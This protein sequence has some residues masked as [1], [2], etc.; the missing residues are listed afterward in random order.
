M[1]WAAPTRA[2]CPDSHCV[3]GSRSARV[4]AR[5]KTLPTSRRLSGAAERRCARVRRAAQRATSAAS[6]TAEDPGTYRSRPRGRRRRPPGQPR[7]T[8]PTRPCSRGAGTACGPRR[9]G[10]LSPPEPIATP[11]AERL[12]LRPRHRD[13]FGSARQQVVRNLEQGGTGDQPVLSGG[14]ARRLIVNE[15]AN[16]CDGEPA[17]CSCVCLLSAGPDI[18]SRLRN[19][20]IPVDTPTC[21]PYSASLRSI[22]TKGGPL[23]VLCRK[24]IQQ[25][26][27]SP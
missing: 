16:C 20:R 5:R 18:E 2:E 27:T 3:S 24:V 17:F 4:A 11:A 6:A 12:D 21:S 23:E 19:D 14:R 15:S 13:Q 1:S 10:R 9:P 22:G 8:P 25:D 7:A 26:P